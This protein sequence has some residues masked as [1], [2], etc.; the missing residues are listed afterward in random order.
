MPVNEL[1][2]LDGHKSNRPTVNRDINSIGRKDEL[3]V[4]HVGRVVRSENFLALVID[5]NG[6]VAHRISPFHRTTISAITTATTI[7]TGIARVQ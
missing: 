1:E 7:T 6:A 4:T 3:D 2:L 5:N